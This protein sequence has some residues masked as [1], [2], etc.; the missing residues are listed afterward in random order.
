MTNKEK[1]L[2]LVSKEETKTVDRAKARIAKKAYTKIS[3]KIAIVILTRLDELKWKQ[4]DLAEKME[5][6]PQQVNKWVKGNENFTLDTLAKLSQVLG[7]EL[8]NVLVKPTPQKPEE[9][10]VTSSDNYSFTN[11][12]KVVKPMITM[13]DDSYYENNYN[14]LTA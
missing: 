4:K 8:I 3:N 14:T 13:S 7:I 10:K 9:V 5:V 11:V 2:N 1:F 12:N 6:S